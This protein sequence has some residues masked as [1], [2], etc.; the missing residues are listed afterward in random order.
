MLHHSLTQA[1]FPIV[2]Q[3]I[4]EKFYLQLLG[5]DGKGKKQNLKD[6]YVERIIHGGLH[7]GQATLW[8]LMAHQLL[9]ELTPGYAH[10][11]LEK[12]ANFLGTDPHSAFLLILTMTTC[13]DAGR[14]GEHEDRWEKESGQYGKQT[15][16]EMLD[17]KHDTLKNLADIFA[18]SIEYK[19]NRDEFLSTL[20]DYPIAEDDY[21]FFD[22]IRLLINLG[23]NFEI[24]RCTP[25]FNIFHIYNTL[26]TIKEFDKASHKHKIQALA[27]AILQFKADHH[28]LLVDCGIVEE[29]GEVIASQQSAALSNERVK[30]EHAENIFAVLFHDALKYP[31]LKTLLGGFEVLAAKT[32]NGPVHINPLVHATN[33]SVF[34]ILPKTNFTFLSVLDMMRDFLAAPMS[35]EITKGGYSQ[36]TDSVIG[37]IA[38]ARMIKDDPESGNYSLKYLLENYT[39]FDVADEVET[40]ISLKQALQEGPEKLFANINLI[41]IYLTRARQLAALDKFVTQD[42]LQA[43]NTD[44][45]A[46]IQ[47]FYFLRL[48]GLYIQVDY[49]AVALPSS[50]MSRL[51]KMTDIACGNLSTKIIITKIKARKINMRHIWLDPTEENLQAVL[52]ILELSPAFQKKYGGTTKLFRLKS[53][54]DIKNAT[55]NVD[56]Y[57]FTMDI[58]EYFRNIIY[59]EPPK[60]SSHMSMKAGV[61]VEALEDRA[62]ILEKILSAPQTAFNLSAEQNYFLTNVFPVIFVTENEQRM[63]LI[64]QNRGRGGEYRS[65]EN[66]KLGKDIKIIAVETEHQQLLLMKFF[67]V[68][69]LPPIQVILISQLNS[70]AKNKT[71][72]YDSPYCHADGVPTLKWLSAQVVS[73]Q[74]LFAKVSTDGE[75]RFSQEIENKAANLVISADCYHGVAFK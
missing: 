2:V 22:Y 20:K 36:I 37:K 67:A 39:K 5:K 57:D 61:M 18:A 13:H 25:A 3:K 26:S 69:A 11:A 41:L 31:F 32:Y 72:Q 51:E 23:D 9:V 12:I 64:V 40:K 71:L 73:K 60:Y 38:F 63:R 14:E 45:H 27:K 52:D 35:G 53:P 68:H 6:G 19:D 70:C 7:A 54:T 50:G 42:H 44:I 48:V 1:N 55:R 4:I 74:G 24:M 59:A 56:N 17:F 62:Q 47:Y 33:S 43:L 10:T 30:Y 15:L 29:D 16:I 28:D 34:A 21:Y 49:T 58:S 66:I 75:A 65:M 46:T 8:A